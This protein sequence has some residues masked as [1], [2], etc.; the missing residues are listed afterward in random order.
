M[1]TSNYYQRESRQ[2]L[3][4][5]TETNGEL[6]YIDILQ[7]TG[8]S[9]MIAVSV[10][11]DLLRSEKIVYRMENGVQYFRINE[12]FKLQEPPT[13]TYRPREVDIYLRF[14]QLLKQHVRDHFSVSDYASELAITPKYL[15]STVSKVSGKSTHR[16]IEDETVIDICDVLEHS[17]LT[18][19][20]IAHLFGFS[21]QSFFCRFFKRKMEISP[22]EYRQ[23]IIRCDEIVNTLDK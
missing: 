14:R 15:T 5:L 18:I 13:N 3:D 10:M 11:G 16:W 23:R 21:N 4:A 22:N 8:I 17:Q 20:E 1:P 2:I 6:T 9:T 12:D 19:K 7:R